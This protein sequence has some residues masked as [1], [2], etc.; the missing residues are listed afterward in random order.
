VTGRPL[1][2]AQERIWFLHQLDPDGVEYNTWVA[3]R[4]R[5]RL[6]AAALGESLGQL[7]V[8]HEIL[9]TTFPLVGDEPVQSI[10]EPR[11]VD[12]W[13]SDLSHLPAGAA[14]ERV[15][16]LLGREVERGFDLARG[17]LLR[18]RLLRLASDEHVLLLTLHHIVFDGWSAGVLVEDLDTLYGAL[19]TGV[20]ATLEPLKLQYADFAEWQRQRMRGEA[21]AGQLAYW[22]ERLRGLE[23]LELPADR[24]RPLASS[25]S[26]GRCHRFRIDG[27]LAAGLRALGRRRGATPF[28]VFAAAFLVLLSRYSRQ[29]RVAIGTPIANR[30]RTELEPLIGVFV[31]TLVL[32]ADLSGDPPFLELLEQVRESA[33][34]AYEH[35]ELPFERL[36][37]E[38]QP[39]RDLARSPLFQ[40][41]FQLERA[42]AGQ[43]LRI[44]DLQAE[45]VEIDE[46]G[47]RFDLSLV[48]QEGAG[49]GLAARLEYS[50]DLFDAATV[51]RFAAHFQNLLRD[52]AARPEA[53]CGALDLLGAEERDR[54]LREWSRTP[55]REAEVCCLHQLL[56]RQAARTPGAAAVAGAGGQLSYAELNARANQLAHELR[57]RGVGPE[58]VVAVCLRRS[59]D[60]VA[61]LLGVLKAGGAYVPLDP[62]HPP[63]TLAA[64]V[65][66]SR[67]SVIVTE[68]WLLD[69]LPERA[70]PVICLTR[71]DA[72]LA[73]NPR[74]DLPPAVH[75]L[76][77]ACVI[78]TSGS[79][80][81]PKAVGMEHRSLTRFAEIQAD[82]FALRAGERVL[83]FAT[84]SFDNHI[85]EIYPALARGATL[86]LRV[87][88]AASSVPHLVA[89]V[90]EAEV[91]V[92]TL[93][94]AYWHELSTALRGGDVS[95][96]ACVRL[97]VTGGDRASPRS[98][99]DWR[100]AAGPHVALLNTY[101]PCETTVGATAVE[102][103]RPTSSRDETN[104][105]IGRPLPGMETYVLD[106]HGRPAPPGVPGELYIGGAGVSR[107]YLGQPGLT[108]ERFLPDPWSADPGGRLYRTGDVVR[109]RADRNLEFLHRTDD[110]LKI[111]GY[112]VEP[113][114]VEAAVRRHDDVR[115]AAVVSRPGPA[116]DTNLVAYFVPASQARPTPLQLRR[117]VEGLLPAYMVP[118]GFVPLRS[119]PMTAVGKVDRARLPSPEDVEPEAPRVESGAGPGSRLEQRLAAIWAEVL[120]VAV[121]RPDDRFFDLG[122]HSLSILRVLSRVRRQFAVELAPQAV[123][124]H[125]TVRSLAAHV[126]AVIVD[127]ISALSDD[128]VAR[129]LADD[130]AGRRE[131]A[132]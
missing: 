44:G 42:V 106:V 27:S 47:S 79:T 103:T 18:A 107:G 34:D 4:L 65:E 3:L 80:G 101:G 22:R 112:R 10:A 73:S 81:R 55:A 77:L 69:R 126:E 75:P 87:D 2:F 117:F 35:Q 84:V 109:F 60:M 91:N 43:G 5:G 41:F 113:A 71:D 124:Q 30:G 31:N 53:P 8:R 6:D 74:T 11:P 58:A 111:R 19:S 93:P 123:F 120:D 108:A 121:V 88:E 33:F 50:A 127:E 119:L 92:L 102:V 96:P 86:V 90:E 125:Q 40:V 100:A 116:G 56:E 118:A 51:E 115:G 82:R 83:Q 95:L 129:R 57:S 66:R 29:R 28:M 24:P 98:L 128:E 72:E 63:A 21:I 114:E 1:S 16:E 48:L 14:E 85:E 52:A 23:P 17:P 76:N 62:D 122:G 13:E 97:V 132:G 37:E 64:A 78:H 36:V 99:R 46:R 38:L 94:A 39:E 20:R 105:P 26:S 104:V 59:L 61:C 131:G 7:A 110:Q 49:D 67:P 9:R 32:D 15:G 54:L 12:V 25:G 89:Q 130:A 68:E 70:A 45:L